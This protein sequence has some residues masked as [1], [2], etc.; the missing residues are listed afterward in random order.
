M[1]LP[2]HNRMHSLPKTNNRCL[3]IS[4][5]AAVCLI[6]MFVQYRELFSVVGAIESLRDTVMYTLVLHRKT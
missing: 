5:F 4:I 6:F 1:F 3:I 2:M